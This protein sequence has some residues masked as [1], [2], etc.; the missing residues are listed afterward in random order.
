MTAEGRPCAVVIVSSVHHGNTR[1]IAE[2]MAEVLQAE[3]RSPADI[4]VDGLLANDLVG[5][6]S[7]IYGAKHHAP[8]LELAESLP[9]AVGKICFLFSTAA[10]TSE[11]KTA[12]DH[13]ALRMILE[14][15]GCRIAGDFS[16][17]GFNTNSFMKYLGGM[18]R[19]RPNA[20]DLDRARSF[21]KHMLIEVG[22]L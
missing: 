5:F 20:E 1:A 2:A 12:A 8:V 13:K 18:N 17:R 4:E 6:G 19:G 7:G 10:F 16:C 15:K 22:D 11:R 3:V 9:E 14:R 21:A